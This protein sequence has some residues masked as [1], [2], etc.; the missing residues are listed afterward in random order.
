MERVWCVERVERRW[1]GSKCGARLDGHKHFGLAVFIFFRLVLCWF[2]FEAAH[3]YQVFFPT[4]HMLR[5]RFV[6]HVTKMILYTRD[7]VYIV[8]SKIC[9]DSSRVLAQI[10]CKVLSYSCT[11]SVISNNLMRVNASTS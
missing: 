8:R 3:L 9:G 2:R 1:V 5:N 10:P 11:L 4:R 6:G 7:A